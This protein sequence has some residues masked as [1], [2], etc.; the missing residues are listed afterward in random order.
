MGLLDLFSKL[1]VE[2]G[3]AE[4][5]SKHI[6]LFKDQLMLADKKITEL[7]TE[8]AALKSKFENAETTI[9]KLTKEN[10][11]LRS[12]IKEYEQTTEHSTHNNLLEEIRGRILYWLS[13]STMTDEQVSNTLQIGLEV[14][15]FHLLELKKT[16]MVK[17]SFRIDKYNHAVSLWSVDQEGRRYLVENKII[18]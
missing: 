7:E 9:E 13:K 17:D 18:A 2:H 3:S 5:Q 1:V 14:A 11:I 16:K 8:N 10:E 6:A 12:K 15:T 4:V